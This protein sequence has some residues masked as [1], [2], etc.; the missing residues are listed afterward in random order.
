MKRLTS[1]HVQATNNRLKVVRRTKPNL[2]VCITGA[3]QGLGRAMTDQFVEHG[4]KVFVVS[5]HDK[6]V[7]ELI[8]GSANV[9]G[10][11]ADIGNPDNF[12]TIFEK[13]C[14]AFDGEV[15]IFLNCAAQSGGYGLMEDLTNE[16]VVDIISTNLLGT[17]LCCK[18]AYDIMKKQESGGAIFNFLGN[19]SSGDSTPN[20]SVYGS[21][22][23]GVKQL[24]L[25][26][27]KEWSAST[28]DLHLIS[29]GLMNTDLLME[30]L[31]DETFEIIRKMCST[32]EVVAYN[33]VPRIR[34]IYYAAKDDHTL[35]FQTVLKIAYKML[36]R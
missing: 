22:K 26:L 12:P 17:C 4:D 18:H 20:Y 33:I 3:S 35:K 13:I 30:N 36:S 5:R 21:T 27:Q 32:P 8:S 34:N 23:C 28:V 7:R 14:D 29:P 25:S 19:G 24:T 31:S 6:D 15:D 2:K 1:I 16:K 11:A 9:Y 10:H